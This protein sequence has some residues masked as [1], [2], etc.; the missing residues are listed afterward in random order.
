[1]G[2]QKEKTRRRG[3]QKGG[4]QEGCLDSG[5]LFF[6]YQFVSEV[7]TSLNKGVYAS[8]PDFRDLVST[9]H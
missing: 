4:P 9:G 8:S 3:S 7:R 5:G 6:C 2:F 1:M